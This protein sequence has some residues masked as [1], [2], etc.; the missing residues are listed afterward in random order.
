MDRPA[1]VIV[2]EDDAPTLEALC[3]SVK[4]NSKLQLI[5]EASNFTSAKAQ[6]TSQPCDLVLLDLVLGNDS[7]LPLITLSQNLSPPPKVLVI[8]VLGD[9]SSV[10][11]AIEL[12][13]NGYLLKEDAMHNLEEAIARVLSDEA[14]ISPAIARHLLRKLQKLPSQGSLNTFD[15]QLSR[16]E[17]Q[18]LDA[19]AQGFSYQ[20][21]AEK[22]S[23]SYHTV[24]DYVKSLYQKLQVGSR[25]EAVAKG[26][27]AGIVRINP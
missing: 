1:R 16:R 2:V 7:A 18:M 6:L 26:V 5:A 3:A 12:G 21:V 8:S 23:I 4:Q 25:G 27:R 15:D 24:A 19:L 22:Y 11:Q 9:E 17:L 20:E 10:I 14:P 13:A